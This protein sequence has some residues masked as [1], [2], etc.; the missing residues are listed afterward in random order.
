M[1]VPVSQPAESLRPLST[2]AATADDFGGQVGRAVQGMGRAVEKTGHD[3]ADMATELKRRRVVRE[4]VDGF[5]K[6]SISSEQWANSDIFSLRGSDTD[7]IGSDDGWNTKIKNNLDK[8]FEQ[9]TKHL[10]P[11]GKQRAA[12]FYAAERMRLET[13]ILSHYERQQHVAELETSELAVDAAVKSASENIRSR[14]RRGTDGAIT[15][16]FVGDEFSNVVSARKVFNSVRGLSGK[17]KLPGGKEVDALP[18]DARGAVHDDVIGTLITSGQFDEA[19]A[20]LGQVV[21][22]D[23]DDKKKTETKSVIKSG[24]EQFIRNAKKMQ[25]EQQF[26]YAVSILKHATEPGAVWTPETASKF[27]MSLQESV[28]FNAAASKGDQATSRSEDYYDFLAE[29]NDYDPKMDPDGTQ[30]RALVKQSLT[31]GAD[32]DFALKELSEVV[33]GIQSKNKISTLAFREARRE[34]IG[35][36]KEAN[37]DPGWGKKSPL[38]GKLSFE[39]MTE[40]GKVRGEGEVFRLYTSLE[41]YLRRMSEDANLTEPQM[42]EAM[43]DHP[44]FK[45]L[46]DTTN[47]KGYAEDFYTLLGTGQRV[48]ELAP[49]QAFDTSEYEA[50]LGGWDAPA[51][52]KAM[53]AIN[54]TKGGN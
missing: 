43:H 35:I 39:D 22:D 24:R 37:K 32:R 9:S 48:G 47:L 16:D 12:T 1:R 17:T 30:L 29:A 14:I 36:V 5:T 41:N 27:G 18:L 34:L 38:D 31:F 8:F 21:K 4:G 20:Y 52:G 53:Q 3:V 33:S 19:Q 49:V 44:A 40:A 46:R 26:Q 2:T 23:Y 51:Y 6:A 42:F 54:S 50:G 10:S 7:F 13:R 45:Q 11:E 28:E 15:F 25:Q